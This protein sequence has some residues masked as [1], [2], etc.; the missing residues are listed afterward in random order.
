MCSSREGGRQFRVC[1]KRIC[2]QSVVLDVKTMD[3][4][5]TLSTHPKPICA[6]DELVASIPPLPTHFVA[7]NAHSNARD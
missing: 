3:P 7:P 1:R 2:I 5:Y 6:H 4:F